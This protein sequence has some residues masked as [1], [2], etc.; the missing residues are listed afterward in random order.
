MC[1]NGFELP[2]VSKIL[3]H[4]D[5]LGCSNRSKGGDVLVY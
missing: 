2:I 4:G 1:D 5:A 3:G